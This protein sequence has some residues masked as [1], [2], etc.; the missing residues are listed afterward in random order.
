MKTINT[1]LIIVICCVFV[2]GITL[3]GVFLFAP[4]LFDGAEENASESPLGIDVSNKDIQNEND[5]NDVPFQPDYGVTE[6]TDTTDENN[7]EVTPTQPDYGLAENPENRPR[8]D[9][10]YDP[11]TGGR[12]SGRVNDNGTGQWSTDGGKTWSDTPPERMP[13]PNN[14]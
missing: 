13:D 12:V 2:A 14:H 9:V 1:V 10:P 4:G 7:Q 3:L 8:E 6:N 5:H 11:V